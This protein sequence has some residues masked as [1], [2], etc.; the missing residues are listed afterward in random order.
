LGNTTASVN[1]LKLEEDIKLLTFLRMLL[2][3]LLDECKLGKR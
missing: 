2:V 3:A 1:D